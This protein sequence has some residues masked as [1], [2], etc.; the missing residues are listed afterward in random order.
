M[1]VE[2]NSI[3]IL[4]LDAS[5]RK[6]PKQQDTTLFVV[7]DDCCCLFLIFVVDSWFLI[8]DCGHCSFFPHYF[9]G[10]HNKNI[11]TSTNKSHDFAS[12]SGWVALRQYGNI[13]FGTDFQGLQ[14]FPQRQWLRHQQGG[15][16]PQPAKRF[17]LFKGFIGLQIA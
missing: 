11:Q 9:F 8:L 3:N 1:R 2:H 17:E 12:V 13:S 16:F 4:N 5:D 10:N 7:V 14:G 6:Y 15:T